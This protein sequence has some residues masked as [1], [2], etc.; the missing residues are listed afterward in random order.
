MSATHADIRS[1]I[2]ESAEDI[3]GNRNGIAGFEFYFTCIAVFT[4][5]KAPCSLMHD[6]YFLADVTV[7]GIG[8][9]RRLAC[10]AYIEAVRLTDVYVL[11][12]V[13]G[14]TGPDDSEIFFLV[15]AGTA[16]IDER[17]GAG[18]QFGVLN[19]AGAQLG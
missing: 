17:V 7:Q 8:A 11:M 18:P 2:F 14:H 16:G 10:A 9:T 5:E 12:G 13:L 6:E 1:D 19:E 15:A 3:N 4:P